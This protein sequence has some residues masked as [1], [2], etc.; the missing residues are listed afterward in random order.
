MSAQTQQNTT[1]LI[2]LDEKSQEF[3]YDNAA[4]WFDNLLLVQSSY[5]KLLED[6]AEKVKELHIHAYL[7]DMAERAR[8]HEEKIDA[9]YALIHR[10]SSSIRKT[11]GTI[12]GKARQALGDLIA[13]SGGIAGPWQDLHQAFL[14]STN[15]MSAFAVAEQIGL[16]TGITEIVD[17]VFPII[18]E[19]S[20]DHLVLQELTLEM[21]G[22]AIVYH[23]SF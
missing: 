19:K 20:T 2:E 12:M 22:V 9:L 13:F 4:K 5:R 17:I 16:A 1:I 11:L 14:A 8:Q 6:T 23:E 15:S 18:M 7:T 10:D 21:A 3:F